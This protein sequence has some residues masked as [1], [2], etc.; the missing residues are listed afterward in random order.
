MAAKRVACTALDWGV[1]ATKIPAENK[2]AFGALKMKLDKH[3][4]AINALPEALPAIDFEVYRSKVAVA[5]MVD[6]FEKQYKALDVPYPGDQ[7]KLKEIDAQAVQQKAA[8]TQFV[9]DS[10]SRIAGF[11]T[12]L[13]KWEAMM[14][15]EEMNLEEAL[16]AGLTQFVIDPSVPSLFPHDQTWEEYAAKLEKADPHDFH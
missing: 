4:R 15:V 14:P 16:D 6:N 2:A 10:K 13:A 1:L 5:G 11:N 7:G 9:A 8:Y 3:T 12:E